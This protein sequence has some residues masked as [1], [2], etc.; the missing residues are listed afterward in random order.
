MSA[1]AAGVRA[2]PKLRTLPCSEPELRSS[3]SMQLTQSAFLAA[4]GAGAVAG[5]DGGGAAAAHS[6]TPFAAAREQE[7]PHEMWS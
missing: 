4:A 7:T 1:A 6:R 2:P 5:G 3:V